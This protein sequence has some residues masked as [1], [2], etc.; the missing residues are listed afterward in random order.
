MNIYFDCDYTI[1]A[2][3]GSLRPG[4]MDVF[5]KLVCDG[6]HLYVWSGVGIR[7]SDME[8]L[9]LTKY[10]SGIFVKPL[11]DFIEGIQ[12]QGIEPWPDFVVDDH[13]EIVEAFGGIHIEPYYF[14][15]A[16]DGQMENLYQAILEYSRDGMCSHRVFKSTPF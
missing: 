6:H 10:I 5:Q 3:D 13:R 14:R 9:E 1:L 4:S 16:E 12:L 15:S 8:R 11:K 2:M 7:T